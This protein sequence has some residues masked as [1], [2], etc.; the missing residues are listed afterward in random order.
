[1]AKND[2]TPS[3]MPTK[4]VVR[5]LCATMIDSNLYDCDQVVRLDSATAQNLI[6]QYYADGNPAAVDHCI[7]V[8][9]EKIIDHDDIKNVAPVAPA[10]EIVPAIEPSI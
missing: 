3:G 5:I 2:P 4:M 8:L 9:G 10:P 7:S 1:M 6:D